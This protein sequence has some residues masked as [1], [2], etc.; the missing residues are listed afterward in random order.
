MKLEEL[1][2]ICEVSE[3]FLGDAIRD[4]PDGK[5]QVKDGSF[6]FWHA[7]RT[8]IPRL[9]A[10]AEAAIRSR[11]SGYDPNGHCDTADRVRANRALWEA[12]AALEQE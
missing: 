3:K 8:M 7:A 6:A 10:V 11:D 12:L 9:I 4:T 2:R 1:K 5:W